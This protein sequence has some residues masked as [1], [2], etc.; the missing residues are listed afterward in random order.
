[1]RTFETGATRDDDENK[2]DYEG[3]LNPEVL[4]CFAEYMHMHRFQADETMRD[5]DNWQ[6]GMGQSVYMK[7]MAR[8]FIDTWRLHR[9]GVR[10]G[11][12]LEDT[13]CALLFN[14]MG[15]LKEVMDEGAEP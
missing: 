7:S 14:V 6:K 1:M 12:E 2:L 10:H 9:F 8:H 5:S 13:L 15:M 3:F 4:R 11:A